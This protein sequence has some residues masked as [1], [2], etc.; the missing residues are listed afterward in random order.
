MG[1]RSEKS[2]KKGRKKINAHKIYSPFGKHSKLAKN[3]SVIRREDDVGG[4][5][6]VTSD[7]EAWDNYKTVA[8]A[9]A[10][11]VGFPSCRLVLALMGF[12]GFINCYTLR[13]NLSVAIVAMVN[14]TYLRE[15][16]TAAAAGDNDT[17]VPVIDVCAVNGDN[18]TN[19]TVQDTVRI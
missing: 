15:L 16:E 9:D 13:V 10:A 14:T 4:R 18:T 17:S 6:R 11:A 7:E 5:V 2:L 8:A 19:H 12:F 1:Y 3:R